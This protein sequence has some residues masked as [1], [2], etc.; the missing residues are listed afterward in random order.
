MRV[1]FLCKRHPQ[2]R[3]LLERP[4]GRFHHLPAGLAARGHEV[5]V[6]LWSHRR[7]PSA[8]R[9][10]AGVLWHADDV[11]SQPLA[12]L[13]RIDGLARA[14]KP[15]WIIGASDT[16]FG[17]LAA[18]LGRRH[19]IRCAIDAYDNF[20][21]YM[22]WAWPLHAAW[23]RA[24]SQASLL[25]AAGP[26]L[27]ERLRAH[28]PAAAVAIVPMAADP[29][30]K[31]L[32]KSA[33]RRL[34]GLPGDVGLV[35]YCGS[36][37]RD[38]GAEALLAAFER[39][40][41]RHPDVRLVSSGRVRMKL[42]AYVQHLGYLAD[43]LVPAFLSSL[44]VACVTAAA[45]AFGCYAYPA[46]LYEALA[47]RVPVVATDVPPIRWIVQNRQEQLARPDDAG[48]LAAR[49][50]EQLVSPWMAPAPP[51]WDGAVERLERALVESPRA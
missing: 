9:A 50:E 1:L 23:R 32:D 18:W 16:Y 22:P 10:M 19:G 46:K 20:E 31:P 42:P 17:I 49:L 43:D 29:A 38:R 51:G 3:D 21:S 39:L 35:G 33:S 37:F 24:L 28:A 12:Y 40:R 25:T 45:N 8:H 47:C 4:Y 44:D 11:L 27:L 34:L 41:R 15:D 2:Q 26:H 48:D 30:F 36:L 7:L 14:S 5:S 6:A 13:R